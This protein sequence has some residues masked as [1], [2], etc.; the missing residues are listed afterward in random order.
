MQRAIWLLLVFVLR[1]AH[2]ASAAEPDPVEGL[3]VFA[4]CVDCHSLSPGENIVGPTLA[5]LWRRKAGGLE[6][7]TGYS[8]A[9]K[10]SGILWDDRT[11]DAWLADPQTVAPGSHAGVAGVSDPPARADLIAFLREVTAP[12]DLPP[13]PAMES[14]EHH[15][16]PGASGMEG[17]GGM[18]ASEPSP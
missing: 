5:G 9:L 17:M 6:S 12:R 3:K 16:A 8:S 14:R 7:F 4:A 13:L 11:L 18:E 10:S 1:I 15:H 2:A